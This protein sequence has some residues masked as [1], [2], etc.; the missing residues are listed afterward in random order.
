MSRRTVAVVLLVVGVLAPTHGAPRPRRAA[1]CTSQGDCGGGMFCQTGVC[2]REPAYGDR[3]VLFGL[4]APA[5]IAPR[6]GADGELA[7][8]ATATL[9]RLLAAAGAFRLIPARVYGPR[10]FIDA[11]TPTGFDAPGWHQSGAYALL[12]GALW[13]T[14]RSDV[15]LEVRLYEV[16]SG[17]PVPLPAARHRVAPH[18]LRAALTR[19][20]QDL[21]LHYTG[22]PGLFGT[23]IACTRKYPGEGKEI[24]TVDLSGEDEVAVTANGSL[25]LL[26]SWSPDGEIA[27]TSY[28]E[29]NPD[30]W[31]GDRKISAREDLN[32]GAAFSPDGR[33]L[34]LTLGKDGNAEI[35][36]L[37]RADGRLLRRLTADPGIDTSPSWSPDG[38]R[39][40]FVSDRTGAPQI[41]TMRANGTEVTALT[42]MGY[43]TNPTWSPMG[44]VIVFDRLITGERSDLYQ[45]HVRSGEVTRLSANGW[46]SEDPSFSPDGRQI[47]FVSTRTGTHQIAVMNADG[48][49]VRQ[50]TLGAGPYAAP[51]WSPVLPTR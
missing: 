26:P 29:G 46:S 41:Y 32:M 33:H 20:A 50:V 17:R 34:A 16:E 21:S 7:A 10:P 4:G 23:R 5:L 2:Q 44:D 22:R 11:P 13:S 48:G 27:Y 6:G 35:Y 15:I 19:V 8:R 25:N 1:F 9:R 14:S 42:A 39:L 3:G 18:E 51:S 49:N 43:N 40:A 45:V 30:L 38:R 37:N 28:R 36:L 31:V 24:V 12:F 47:A